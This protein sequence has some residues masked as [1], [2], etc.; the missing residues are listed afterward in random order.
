MRLFKTVLLLMLVAS[1]IPTAM[2]GWLSVSDTRELLVRNAQELADE[3]V[4]QLMIRAGL[5]LEEPSRAVQG[6]AR[7]PSF[8]SLPLKEQRGYIA[9]ILNQ[10]REITAVTVFD[11]NG[12]RVPG[13]Q[14]FAV[15]DVPPTEVAEH[16]ERAHALLSP[17]GLRYSDVSFSRSRR[18]PAVTLAFPVGDPVRGYVAA[19]VDLG[20]LEEIVTDQK[21]GSTGF[22]YVVDRRG[23]LVAGSPGLGEL[24]VASDLTARPAVHHLMDTLKNSPDPE[25][26]RVGNFGEGKDRVVGAYSVLPEP[27]WAVISEQPIDQAYLQVRSMERRIVLGLLSAIGVAL[28]LAALFSESLTRPIKRFKGRALEIAKGT[29]GVQVV[30]KSKN[31]LGELAQTFNYMSQQLLAYDAENKG[32]YESLEKGYLETIV[33]L[34]NSIDSKDAYTRGHSQRVGDISVEIGRELNLPERELKQLQYGGILHDIGKIG[35]VEQILCKKAKLTDEEMVVM[36]EHPMIGA[37]IIEPV[38]FLSSVLAAVKSHHE[39]WDGS[40]YPEGLKGE[41][42]P[43][44]ARIV[45]CADTFDAC[46]STRPY[47]KAMPL[48]KAM[49]IMRNLRGVGLDANVVDALQRYLQKKGVR[50][51]GSRQPVK[52]AS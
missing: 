4:Q 43:M 38:S 15:K 52:L 48:E 42:I 22:A 13:L 10:R 1:L 29:F 7:I 37:S 18:K 6:L 45:A 51:E 21:V 34:A 12:T 27:G 40:G 19:E 35:I 14:A 30:L 50:L 16:E 49:E 20:R 32:L 46:T 44:I 41:A 23:R 47:Q 25:L 26:S 33:S 31:E 3:R 17:A 5:V 28:L 24:A 11:A 2:V 9:A 8:F 36:R 39:R